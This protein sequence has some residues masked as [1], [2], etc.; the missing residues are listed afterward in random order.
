MELEELK[1]MWNDCHK[2]INRNLKLNRR[3]LKEIN[4]DKM[5]SRMCR[6]M[7]FRIAEALCFLIIVIALWTFIAANPSLSA[8]TI[9]ALILNVFATVGLAGSIGQIALIGMIDYSSSVTSIQKQLGRIKSHGIQISKLLFLSIPFYMS[10]VFLGSK[11]FFKIDLYASADRTWLILNIVISVC[12]I[13]PALW[14]YRELSS[15][16]TTRNWVKRLAVSSGGK[17]ITAAS[18]FM[19]EIEKFENE[20]D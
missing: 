3:I 17:E 19:D 20:D 2:K 4:L 9:S 12:F 5:K 1:K 10:Y 8:P 11:L 7:T 14:L 6:L 15:I 13:I 16:S 18:E